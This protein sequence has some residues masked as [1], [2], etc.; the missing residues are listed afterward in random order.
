MTVPRTVRAPA[1]L[2][3]LAII[4][5]FS[6]LFISTSQILLAQD[7][8]QV[9][10][11][12]GRIE[13]DG[14]GNLFLLPD[15]K[16]GETLYIYAEGTSGNL[17]PAAM[18]LDS[19]TPINTLR[20]AFFSE[21]EEAIAEGEDPLALIP[22]LTRLLTLAYDDDSGPGYAAALEFQIPFDGDYRLLMG[23]TVLQNTF[24][25]YRLLVGVNAPEVLR[26]DARPTTDGIAFLN[27]D[28]LRSDAAIEEDRGALSA[29]KRSTFY[30]LHDLQPGDT[31]YAYV[32]TT[33]GSLRPILSLVDAGD[34]L[35]RTGNFSGDATTAALEYTF[36]EVGTNFVLKLD[37][38]CGEETVTTGEYRLLVG[39]NAPE[40]LTGE[41]ELIRGQPILRKTIPVRIGVT[42]D[43]ITGVDQ[44]AENFGAVADLRMEWQDPALAFSPDSCNCRF[45]IYSASDFT[46]FATEN[47][48]SW[49]EF[50]VFNQQNNRWSQSPIVAVFPDGGAIYLERF[51]TTLQAPDFDFTLFP[52]DKQRFFIRVD[53]VLPEE[54]FQFTDPSELSGLG[55]QLGEE[56]WIVTE[57][58]TEVSTV[59][60]QNQASRFSFG[61]RAQRHLNFYVFRFFIPITIIIVVSWVTFFLQ[62][63]GKRI[64]VASGNLLLFIAYNFTISDDL[65]RL[66]YLTLMDFILISTFIVTALVIVFNVYLKLLETRK[67]TNVA[68]TIDKYMIWL[69]PLA[70]AIGAGIV[71]Y[72]VVFAP[73]S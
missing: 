37:S 29:N 16:Q 46:K 13:Q 27:T 31:L 10:E 18:V 7:T 43:Q 35:T 47:N 56:E 22:T 1:F 25:D 44:K 11:I 51:T 68:N 34:K 55:E 61:F 42:M 63:Y 4:L 9:Q 2:Q 57:F 60:K 32:E 65:P 26:G 28:I 39:V 64:D 53:S 36:E 67:R 15:R 58:G 17:D 8:R 21:I 69:Y 12:T 73:Q 52:F 40:V 48:I 14:Q 59:T 30:N 24:G 33:T 19:T 38:C 71:L 41:A 70:Y 20:A 72:L 6:L 45:K 3:V 54:L 66:G 49:P 23:S 5:C 62:D 50:V